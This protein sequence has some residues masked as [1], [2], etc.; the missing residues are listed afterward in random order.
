MTERPADGEGV[1]N[2]RTRL[3]QAVDH[4]TTAQHRNVA[5][6]TAAFQRAAEAAAAASDVERRDEGADR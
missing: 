6:L 1:N 2:S 4:L 5:A 3:H